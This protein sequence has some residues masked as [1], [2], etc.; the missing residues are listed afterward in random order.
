MNNRGLSL[1]TPWATDG[2]GSGAWGHISGNINGHNFSWGPDGWDSRDSASDYINRQI[3]YVHRDGIGVVLD[4]SPYEEY[5]LVSFLRQKK[6]PY[7]GITNNCGNPWISCLQQLGLV[8]S[9]DKRRVLPSDVFDI[10]RHSP[11]AISE[12][13]YTGLGYKGF[14]VP[15]IFPVIDA[16][17]RRFGQ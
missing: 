13:P 16:I 11:R 15:P 1:I 9:T 12:N 4:L 3:N 8:N 2:S 14:D 5:R 10:I 7:G 17:R 6:G